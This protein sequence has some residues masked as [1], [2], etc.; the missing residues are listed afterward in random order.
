MPRL[1]TCAHRT[2]CPCITSRPDGGQ[3]FLVLRVSEGLEGNTPARSP[4]CWASRPS[5]SI[6]T[7]RSCLRMVW[8]SR[9]GKTPKRKPIWTFSDLNL[10]RSSAYELQEPSSTF[11]SAQNKPTLIARLDKLTADVRRELKQQGFEGD[12]VVVERMLNM[13]FEGTD[14]ALMVLPDPKDGDG[15][16]DFEAAFKRV[17]MAEFGFLLETKSIIVDDI[18]VRTSPYFRLHSS[19]GVVLTV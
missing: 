6:D 15:R 2:S 16:E 19:S 13:R 8:L 17:Y 10:I 11:Y 14:T 12:R 3:T 7:A 4:A 5:W 18:K 1:N 9:I